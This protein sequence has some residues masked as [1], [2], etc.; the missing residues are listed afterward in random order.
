MALIARHCNL[1]FRSCCGVIQCKKIFLQ[2]KSISGLFDIVN[3]IFAFWQ[4]LA[5]VFIDC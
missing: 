1:F 4:D 2:E 5:D 3:S